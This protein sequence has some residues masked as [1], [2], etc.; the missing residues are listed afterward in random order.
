[1][2]D[3]GG[4][5]G[6]EG[7]VV[8][9]FAGTEVPERNF[10][11]NT[12]EDNIQTIRQTPGT[13]NRVLEGTEDSYLTRPGFTVTLE[14]LANPD[15]VVRDAPN[16]AGSYFTEETGSCENPELPPS[17]PIDR[18][19]TSREVLETRS[20]D[21]IRNI[22]IDRTDWYRCDVREA[23]FVRFCEREESYA[24]SVETTQEACIRNSIEVEA[25]DGEVS[26][27]GNTVRIAFEAPPERDSCALENGE[28]ICE[29]DYGS[30]SPEECDFDEF[31]LPGDG[32]YRSCYI[33]PADLQEHRFQ[34][35][36]SDR[37]H[38]EELILRRVESGGV[39]QLVLNDRVAHV[40]T[41]YSA[42]TLLGDDY[43]E[44]CRGGHMERLLYP[45]NG[46]HVSRIGETY[47]FPGVGFAHPETYPEETLRDWD[48]TVPQFESPP[49]QGWCPFTG[50][51]RDIWSGAWMNYDFATSMFE[52]LDPPAFPPADPAVP[53]TNV[54]D[55]SQR[56][57]FPGSSLGRGGGAVEF[58]FAGPCCDS[59]AASGGEECEE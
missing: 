34:I 27:D 3:L 18:F 4:M 13:Q 19:C 15:A 25:P 48:N 40:M 23:V 42:E 12:F 24:C 7:T 17:Q 49:D 8:I 50:F 53:G 45:V 57:I 10:N 1:M 32:L 20:C 31:G 2:P 47:I 26:W 38:L 59:F 5:Q 21:Q 6:A 16:I 41:D 37:M 39:G 29:S 11:P 46:F 14:D 55:G 9:P 33:N 54:I 28:T 22:W 44:A 56:V 36:L 51:W 35:R 58:S 30:P 43:P 52:W